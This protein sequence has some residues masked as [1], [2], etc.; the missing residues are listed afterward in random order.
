MGIPDISTEALQV[1]TANEAFYWELVPWRIENGHIDC[2][3][4]TGHDYTE[5]ESEKFA[6]FLYVGRKI[7]EQK[8]K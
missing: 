3:G 1:F 4:K 5:A 8:L 6:I 7:L 2:L